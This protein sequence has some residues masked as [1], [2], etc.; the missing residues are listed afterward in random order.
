MLLLPE[1]TSKFIA[2]TKIESHFCNISMIL[3][4]LEIFKI[5]EENGDTILVCG[6]SVHH[7]FLFS[8]TNVH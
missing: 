1:N 4:A 2:T 5:P 6:I 7:K 8:I 3:V